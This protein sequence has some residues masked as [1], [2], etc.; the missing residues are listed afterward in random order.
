MLRTFIDGPAGS[1]SSERPARYAWVVWAL[2]VV[3][4]LTPGVSHAQAV[5]SIDASTVSV[6]GVEAG[7]TVGIFGLSRFQGPLGAVSAAPAVVAVDDD[8]DG[9][10]T[11]V[12][13]F[14][15]DGQ[16]FWGATDLSVGGLSLAWSLELEPVE[17][18]LDPTVHLI[19]GPGG[20]TTRL[21]I[22]LPSLSFFGIRPGVGVWALEAIDGGPADLG[23]A[24]DGEI[25]LDLSMATAVDG[26]G[27]V[28]GPIVAGDL[29]FGC[30]I[31]GVSYFA[32]EVGS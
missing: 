18:P 14:P 16:S 15:L 10:V 2:L 29:L 20:P 31:E 22:P 28:L 9:L 24:G 26:S 7:T 11:W 25:S 21:E 23:A 30:S 4:C 17:L 1:S 19:D 6:S 13:G 3:P 32:L 8:L 27:A 5:V 12:P